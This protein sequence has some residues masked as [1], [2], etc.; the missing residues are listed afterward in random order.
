MVS[1]ERSGVLNE[2]VLVSYATPYTSY[3]V[4][5]VDDYTLQNFSN[6]LEHCAT[7][8][9]PTPNYLIGLSSNLP[10]LYDGSRQ[11]CC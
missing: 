7:S 6:I 9:A 3:D 8:S 10:S 11:N 4:V 2:R 1:P 5:R